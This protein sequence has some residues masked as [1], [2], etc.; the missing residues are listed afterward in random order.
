MFAILTDHLFKLWDFCSLKAPSTYWI[1]QQL[2]LPL[3][4]VYI[5]QFISKIMT[6]KFQNNVRT[7]S[8]A[9]LQIYNHMHCLCIC[10]TSHIGKFLHHTIMFNHFTACCVSSDVTCVSRIHENEQIREEKKE[11]CYIIQ[12]LMKLGNSGGE[13]ARK[14][15]TVYGATVLKLS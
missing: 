6:I 15:W 11:Q 5:P 12:F 9:T 2:V 8:V 3:H 10:I 13:V 1:R 14:L 7:C 4:N